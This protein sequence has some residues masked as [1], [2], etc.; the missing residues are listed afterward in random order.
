MSVDKIANIMWH[1]GKPNES[2]FC[3]VNL[4]DHIELA[5][6]SV[7][8]FEGCWFKHAEQSFTFENFIEDEDIKCW[9][10]AEKIAQLLQTRKTIMKGF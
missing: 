1:T 6:Y 4:G 7:N 5:W 8:A 3:F 2:C 9:V 10:K